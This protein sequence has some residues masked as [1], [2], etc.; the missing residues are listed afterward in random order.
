MASW[1]A[2]T[3]E[4]LSG[5]RAELRRVTWPDRAQLKQ[6]TIAIIIFVLIVGGIIALMDLVLQG[7]LV[8]GLPSLFGAR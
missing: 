4:F 6:A 7:V 8:R 3:G 2:Q 1:V 5:V